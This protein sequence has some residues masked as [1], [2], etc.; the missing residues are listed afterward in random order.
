MNLDELDQKAK[1]LARD[2]AA[3]HLARLLIIEQ[4]RAEDLRNMIVDIR[5]E[6]AESELASRERAKRR[7]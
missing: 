2:K 4:E 5:L 6:L 7:G 1:A 3:Y